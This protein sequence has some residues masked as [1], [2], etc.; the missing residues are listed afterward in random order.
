MHALSAPRERLHRP[1]ALVP[2]DVDTIKGAI[3]STLADFGGLPPVICWES[4]GDPRCETIGGSELCPAHPLPEKSEQMQK[5]CARM[6]TYLRV[7]LY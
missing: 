6:S 2:Q 3:V 5:V 4:G 7:F 1:S